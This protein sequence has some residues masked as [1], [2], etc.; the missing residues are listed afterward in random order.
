MNSAREY[1]TMSN[2]RYVERT[3]AEVRALLEGE[4]GFVE[5]PYT[6]ERW[7]DYIPWERVWERQVVTASGTEYPYYIVCYS[8]VERGNNVTRACGEDAI[9]FVLLNKNGKPI[10]R[11]EKRV[12]RTK[13]ALE[14]M[15]ER[16]RDLYRFVMGSETCPKCNS[17]M[18]ERTV[19]KDGPNK[20]KKFL[21]CTDYPNCDGTRWDYNG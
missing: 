14:N 11:A 4:M 9:R 3:D 19:K 1:A 20:G 13:G 10:T 17:L 12:F 18:D 7:G 6:R 5:A 21:G 16:A 8:T 2:A 15:R